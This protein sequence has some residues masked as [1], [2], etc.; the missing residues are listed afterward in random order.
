MPIIDKNEATANR[1]TVSLRVFQDDG[2]TP[3]DRAVDFSAFLYVESAPGVFALGGGTLVNK[4]R[5]LVIADDTVDG[6]NTSTDELT[7][8][9]HLYENLDGPITPTTTS[10]GL[11]AGTDY[12]VI[13]VDANT[14]ALADSLAHA[15]AGTKVDI[16]ADVTGMIFQDKATTQRGLDGEFVYTLTQGET[17]VVMDE[18]VVMIIDCTISLVNYARSMSFVTLQPSVSVSAIVDAAVNSIW[19]GTGAVIE[20]AAVAADLLRLFASVLAGKVSDFRTGVQ[21]WKSLD[22]SK[23]RLTGTTDASG[24]LTTVLG[25]LT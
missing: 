24:R 19:E 18:L 5:A 7:F 6:T 10:G 3:A 20:G 22:G 16:T 13:Y 23:T 12:W 11:A 25:D 17:N 21:T 4:R 1:R 14:V 9:G 2:V 15:I 8:T